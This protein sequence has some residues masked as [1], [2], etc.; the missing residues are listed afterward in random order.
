MRDYA[1]YD[2]KRVSLLK[3]IYAKPTFSGQSIAKV[4]GTALCQVQRRVGVIPEYRHR[5][6]FRLEGRQFAEPDRRR[7]IE[8][9]ADLDL[10]FLTAREIQIADILG[11]EQHL[12]NYGC[13]VKQTHRLDLLLK[14]I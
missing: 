6:H 3:D 9:A 14:V 5:D 12:L 11:N 2:R 7:R 1:H 10:R 13:Y 8:H 4:R